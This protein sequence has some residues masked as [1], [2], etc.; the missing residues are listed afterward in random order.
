MYPP[1]FDLP[2]SGDPILGPIARISPP[3]RAN[4]YSLYS[5]SF[6]LGVFEV[7]LLLLGS[8]SCVTSDDMASMLRRCSL[9]STPR[10]TPG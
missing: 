10:V 8:S 4:H 6:V 2:I 1:P 3:P 7:V 9:L 5:T